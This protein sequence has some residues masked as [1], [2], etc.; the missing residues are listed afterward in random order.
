MRILILTG[1]ASI[2][3]AVEAIK[4]GAD[5]YLA[6]PADITEILAALLTGDPQD[7]VRNQRSVNEPVQPRANVGAAPGMGTYPESTTGKRWQYLGHRSTTKNA[8][9]HLATQTSKAPGREIV[10]AVQSR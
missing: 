8:S 5:N 6:K 1:Y 10:S 9:P 3:T 2:A 4:R 7:V